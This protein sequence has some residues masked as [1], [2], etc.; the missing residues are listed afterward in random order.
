MPQS[1]STLL[2][3]SR[4]TAWLGCSSVVNLSKSVRPIPVN[5]TRS[6]SP[7]AV[8]TRAGRWTGG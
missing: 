1:A 2:L 3:G 8:I 7:G 5:P 6:M 4:A